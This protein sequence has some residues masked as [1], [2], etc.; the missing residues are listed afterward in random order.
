MKG[1][2]PSW[3]PSGSLAPIRKPNVMPYLDEKLFQ[4]ELTAL[5]SSYFVTD[6]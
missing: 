6:Q 2:V 5:M 1:G 3:T 4:S